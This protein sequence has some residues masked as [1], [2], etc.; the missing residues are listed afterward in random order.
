MLFF[1]LFQES[2]QAVRD[3]QKRDV[4]H[5]CFVSSEVK[6]GHAMYALMSVRCW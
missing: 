3:V 2:Y 4:L 1:Q 6:W 5:V